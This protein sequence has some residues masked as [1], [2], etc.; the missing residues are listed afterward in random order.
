MTSQACTKRELVSP[1]PIL[2][3]LLSFFGKPPNK[4]RGFS[5]VATDE[6]GGYY[7]KNGASDA[8]FT[9]RA[10]SIIVKNC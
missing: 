7:G 6:P 8:F 4:G 2:L 9:D 5:F 3:L 10:I 1:R